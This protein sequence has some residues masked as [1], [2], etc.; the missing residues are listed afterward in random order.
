MSMFG[1]IASAIFGHRSA[2]SRAESGES[3]GSAST[4]TAPSSSP[5][6]REPSSSGPGTSTGTSAGDTSAT[7]SGERSPS[8][9][10]TGGESMPGATGEPMAPAEVEIIIAQIAND[11]DR[12]DYNWDESIVD[13]LRLLDIDSGLESRQQLARELGYTG[14]LDDSPEMNQWL[15]RE[16]MSR[17]AACGG[18]VPAEA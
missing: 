8:M 14:G 6:V 13:L 16:V 7:S 3:S 5:S 10:P 4:G 11:T 12:D 1:R 17:L 2:G 9:V 15:H 18:R